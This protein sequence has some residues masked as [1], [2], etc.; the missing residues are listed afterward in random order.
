MGREVGAFVKYSNK[1]FIPLVFDKRI[2]TDVENPELGN[3]ELQRLEISEGKVTVSYIFM[4]TG[5]GN[6][7]G[8]FLKY[9]N[10]KT[11]NVYTLF[12]L[13]AINSCVESCAG[14]KCRF[15]TNSR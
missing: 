9:R 12:N 4:Q 2:E 3:Y 14:N 5:A 7:Q 11:K 15:V 13:G 6:K 10:L 1:K 8:S